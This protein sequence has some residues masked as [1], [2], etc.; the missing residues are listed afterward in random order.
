MSNDD[1]K[2]G[3]DR[4]SE[5]GSTRVLQRS[6]HALS[7]AISR[8]DARSDGASLTQAP[9]SVEVIA[10]S[11]NSTSPGSGQDM[12]SE[13]ARQINELVTLSAER[14]LLR[15]QLEAA[16]A[17]KAAPSEEGGEKNPLQEW[18]EELE[19]Q[20]LKAPEIEE[21][22][23]DRLRALRRGMLAMDASRKVGR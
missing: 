11:S 13:I 6:E 15:E 23:V 19:G 22:L 12:R 1:R 20:G 2:R 14:G 7:D 3:I 18:W 10:R 21:M 16:R 8:L 9:T 4:L 5:R 17:A